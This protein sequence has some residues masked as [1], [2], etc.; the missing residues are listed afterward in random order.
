MF[1]IEIEP[2]I[3]HGRR[4]VDIDQGADETTHVRF[5]LKRVGNLPGFP[6]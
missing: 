1:P 4:R 3:E 6:E 5:A 2:W